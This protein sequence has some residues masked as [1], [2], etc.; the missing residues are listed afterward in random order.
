MFKRIGVLGCKA[1]KSGIKFK[2][3]NIKVISQ[4]V[5]YIT[6]RDHTIYVDYSMRKELIINKWH[7]TED[8]LHG[9]F[10]NL[11]EKS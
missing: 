2:T 7:N 11:A 3:M 8:D 6:M 10:T 1:I 9:T 5:V 4:N